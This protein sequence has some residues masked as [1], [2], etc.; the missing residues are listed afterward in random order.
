LEIHFT[1][2]RERELDERAKTTFGDAARRVQRRISS[3]GSSVGPPWTK[4]HKTA[5]LAAAMILAQ[6]ETERHATEESV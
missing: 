4:D 6:S 5:A 3:L 1:A 2:I